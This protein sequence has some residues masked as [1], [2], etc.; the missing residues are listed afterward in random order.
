MPTLKEGSVKVL[1]RLQDSFSN[2]SIV[3]A[4]YDTLSRTPANF[5]SKDFQMVIVVSDYLLSLYLLLDYHI[6]Y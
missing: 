6:Y 5:T 4:S 2:A 3:I 1:Y